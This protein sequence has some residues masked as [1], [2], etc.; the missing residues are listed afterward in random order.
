MCLWVPAP[1]GE[2]AWAISHLSELSNAVFFFQVIS[3]NN[4]G[5]M[6]LKVVTD[7]VSVKTH[8]RDLEVPGSGKDCIMS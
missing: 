2:S 7:M 8:F 3:A 1:P 5:D 4:S 6:T